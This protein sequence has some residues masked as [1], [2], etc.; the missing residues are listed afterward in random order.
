MLGSQNQIRLMKLVVGVVAAIALG[1][2]VV[3]ARPALAAAPTWTVEPSPPL[4]AQF[5]AGELTAVG[6][7]A[8]TCLAVG[9]GEDPYEEPYYLSDQW[10]G[11]SWTSEQTPGTNG[12]G[13]YMTGVACPTATTCWAT[14]T[15]SFQNGPLPVLWS[16]GQGGWN[17]G[18]LAGNINTGDLNG[19]SCTST[20]FCMAV[21]D[22]GSKALAERWD[23]KRW[24][25][26]ALQKTA[27][28]GFTGPS[29][30]N[31]GCGGPNSCMAVGLAKA[32]GAL[33]VVEHWNGKSWKEQPTPTMRGAKGGN[34]GDVSC[35]T[36]TECIAVGTYKRGSVRLALSEM[37]NGRH[38]KLLSTPNQPLSPKNSALWSISCGAANA[39]AA[40][41][42]PGPYPLLEWWDGTSW[43]LQPMPASFPGGAGLISVSCSSVTD[44]TAVGDN[45]SRSF[46]MATT[47]SATT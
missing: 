30:S 18:N 11:V 36:A 12:N 29:F 19:I 2:L 40:V 27:T 20:Q 24:H 14:G 22:V 25:F 6:C 15:A 21:G 8:S 34:L 9:D 37:W 44:C 16:L 43:T 46:A 4:P 17:D 45:G 23:G 7:A 33:G 26:M 32:S 35:P 38:W 41:G 13:F 42:T 31:V 10:N 3:A 1:F 47:T 5:S 39:C 28:P